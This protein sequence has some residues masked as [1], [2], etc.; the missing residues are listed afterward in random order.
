V[1]AVAALK[2]LGILDPVVQKSDDKVVR[3]R[4]FEFFSG[5]QDHERI[6]KYPTT[7]RTL[8][9]G[10]LRSAMLDALVEILPPGIAHLNK[11]C[12][13]VQPGSPD[14]SQKATIKFADGSEYQAD[15]VVG[16][17][18]VKSV[19]RKAVAEPDRNEKNVNGAVTRT[20]YMN[21]NVYRGLVPFDKLKSVRAEDMIE[22]PRIYSGLDKHVI[23]FPMK[24]N[25]LMNVHAYT[26]DRSKPYGELEL[27]EGVARK[28]WVAPAEHEELLKEYE[29][30]GPQVQEILSHVPK[31]SKWMVHI[32][33]PPLET[34]VR[35]PN[36]VLVGDSAHAMLPHLGAG[37]GQC[38]EDVHLLSKLL[39]HQDTTKDKLKNVLKAYDHSRVNRANAVVRESIRAGDIWQGRGPSGPVF[40]GHTEDIKDIWEWVWYID[41]EKSVTDAL[42][43]MKQLEVPS[44]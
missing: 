3:P 44:C 27:P 24:G 36:V 20:R 38:L 26:C 21:T 18:G 9:L 43:Y 6:H 17:D 40:E 2:E 16:C 23:V 10:M 13:S 28:T 31:P 7:E 25:T 5:Y 42:E 4:S 1:N 29:G 33:D 14:G 39:T 12:I 15:L 19:V 41:L 22:R 35:Q 32:I 34:Y 37:V 11:R 30:W 8:G